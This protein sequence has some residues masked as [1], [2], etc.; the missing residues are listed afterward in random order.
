M[1]VQKNA[2]MEYIRGLKVGDIYMDSIITSIRK[3]DRGFLIMT[4]NGN[5]YNAHLKTAYYNVFQTD[6][7]K[8]KHL[9]NQINDI[10]RLYGY[11]KLKLPKERREKP[12]DPAAAAG[13]LPEPSAPEAQ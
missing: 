5:L 9:R 10:Y 6:R 1:L 12:P 3:K 8:K 11:K 13:P 7:H 2:S 4:S